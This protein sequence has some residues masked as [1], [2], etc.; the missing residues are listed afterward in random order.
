[1]S[2][3]AI[4]E[5]PSILGLKRTGVE[6][7]PDA[8]KGAGLLE[9][10]DAEHAGRVESLSYNPA[11]DKETLLLNP[12][13]IREFSSR[14]ASAVTAVMQRNQLLVVLGGDC[15]ILIGNLLALRRLGTY[16]LFFID[17]HADFYQPEASLTGEVADMDLAIVSGR[18][19]EVLTDIDGMRPLVYDENVV[20]FGYRDAKESASYGSQDV[21]KSGIY[22]LDLDQ[23]RELGVVKAASQ[24]LG[25]LQNDEIKGIWVHLDVDVLNDTEMPAVDYRMP[26]GM[27]FSELGDLLRI[28]VDSG[29][30]VGMDVT[31][32][33]P[34]LDPD[35]SMA[36]NLVT[37]LK[38]SLT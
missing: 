32:F 20:L 1:M 14:L 27:T 29:Q 36:R 19:P 17:G 23:V 9:M 38:R 24:A 5:A 16:G 31:I 22:A 34:N 30:I 33:N 37:T 21:R 7:L 6:N 10:L 4:I 8:L 25:R 35:G 15:S 28:L 2:R 11:R 3:I 18:G 26:G 12:Q 13:A